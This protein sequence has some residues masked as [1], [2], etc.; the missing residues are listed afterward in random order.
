MAQKRSSNPVDRKA[1]CSIM[2]DC[3]GCEW[4]GL[5]YRKQL[6]RKHAAMAELYQPLIDRFG[7]DVE[8]APVLGMGPSGE[9]GPVTVEDA[10][11]ASP[12]AFRHKAS[13]PF[14]PGGDGR[15]M[16]GF[17]AR[18]SHAIV[19]CPACAVEAPG[20]RETLNDVA[21]IATELG[22]P[23]YDE[24]RRQGQLRH[25]IVRR[26]WR[27]GESMLTLVTRSREVPRLDELVRAISRAHPE[28]VTIAQNVNPRITNAVLGGETRV[29]HGAARMRDQLLDCTFEISPVSFYQVNP[30]QTE[31]LYLQAIE[32]MALRDGDTV[33]DTYCGSGT[34][35][36]AAASHARAVGS[37]I[38]LIGV[39]RNVEGVRD[40][41][42]NAQVNDLDTISEFIARDATEYM[43]DAAGRRDAVD[44]LVMDPPRA[45][46]TPAFVDAVV[47]LGPRRIVYISCNPV[48]QVR[49][50]ELFGAAGYRVDALTPVDL[51]PHTSHT[52]M[53]AT[54]SRP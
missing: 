6:A 11:L 42:R 30:Q 7:W 15:V 54:L 37:E 5:P 41:Q 23:A 25:A 9:S 21:R 39:E 24:D 8:V 12:R 14:A 4:L 40:A 16:S 33:L 17:F 38:R 13:T 49:D 3:G 26:G 32:G 19:P 47:A 44:V 35:G 51:F 18:G 29:L 43:G 45:G 22:I 36:L 27:T 20:A 28:L 48:T 46:S 1:P 50:L 52:E 10:P 31:V 34:I 53:V 2:R